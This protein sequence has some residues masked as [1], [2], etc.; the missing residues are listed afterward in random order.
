MQ[1]ATLACLALLIAA[2][3]ASAPNDD[4]PATPGPR[5]D[6]LGQTPPGAEPVLFAPGVVSTGL[7]DRDVAITPDGREIYFSVAGPGYAWMTIL[8]ARRL[9]DGSWTRPAAAAFT[10]ALPATDIEPFVAPGGQRL[11]FVSDRSRG[12]A[13]GATADHDV[14]FADRAAEGWSEPRNLGA[15]VNSPDEEYFPSLTRDGTLYFTREKRGE[16]AGFIYRSRRVGAGWAEPER[17]PE[18]VNAGKA[19]FN[20]FVAP[21]ESYLILSIV[22]R[23]DAIGRSD[24][25]VCF[26]GA[27]DSWSEPVNLGERINVPRGEGYSPFVSPDGRY[28]FFM[29]RRRGA[30]DAMKGRR[31]ETG[32]IARLGSEPEN[33]NTDTYWVDA[34]FIERLR[35]RR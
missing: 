18:A 17:L 25:Y 4:P 10:A 16:A 23:P 5:G 6:Y 14:W 9:P 13:P 31:L 28:F 21:D 12:E 32:D 29:S 8:F 19:R 33:G 11:Y 15:P 35:P 24:Y 26:R 34:A 3:L 1:P 27:D 20:A 7:Y 2:G 22:G 30:L